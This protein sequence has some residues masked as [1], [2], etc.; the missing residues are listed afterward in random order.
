[1]RE[2]LRRITAV[3]LSVFL[4]LFHLPAG[5]AEDTAETER[6][7]ITPCS[8]VNFANGVSHYVS[9]DVAFREAARLVIRLYRPDG[10]QSSF[11]TRKHVRYGLDAVRAVSMETDPSAGEIK[12]I[13]IYFKKACTP[14]TWRITATAE[15]RKKN[16]LGQCSLEVCVRE[17]ETPVPADYEKVY[18]VLSGGKENVEAGRVRMVAQIPEDPCFVKALWK[19]KAYDLLEDSRNMCTR[20]VFSMAVSYLGIDCSPAGMSEITRSRELFYTYEAVAEKLGNLERVEGTVEELFALYEAGGHSPVC[21]HFTY[22]DSGMHALLLLARDSLNP[23]MYYALDPGAG[24]NALA[25]GGRKHEHIIPLIIDE[26]RIGNRIQSPLIQRY[27]SAQLD[28][29]WCWKLKDPSEQGVPE[30]AEGEI[31]EPAG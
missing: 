26:G 27:N 13:E 16:V 25:V 21:I 6:M 2:G 31:Q 1:M 5:W 20:A 17:A 10:S 3:L 11:K 9:F 30:P 14:G 29:I 7:E 19:N 15:D 18:A 24:V 22:S 12:N 28:E 4:C 8:I 23:E